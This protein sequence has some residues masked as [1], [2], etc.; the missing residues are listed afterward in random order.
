MSSF[1]P[2]TLFSRKPDLIAAEVDGDQVMMSIE[3]GE[4]FGIT[5][6]GSHV[7]EL[8]ARPISIAEITDIICTKYDVEEAQ[9]RSDMQSFVEELFKLGLVSAD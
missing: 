7:W 2:S 5:G 9:C 3:Q 6:V 8:L 4:Y 1:P